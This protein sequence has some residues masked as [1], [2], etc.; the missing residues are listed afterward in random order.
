MRYIV[1]ESLAKTD[2]SMAGSAFLL[3]NGWDDWFKFRTLFSLVVFDYEGV[4]HD[5]GHLKI[6]QL[7]LK[8]AG[9]TEPGQ[10]SPQLPE[11]FEELGEQFFSLGQDESYYETLWSL[12]DDVAESILVALRD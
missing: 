8:P 6:G 1:S 4:R 2:Q 12:G 5:I 11:A 9:T 10:R 3:R 7:G